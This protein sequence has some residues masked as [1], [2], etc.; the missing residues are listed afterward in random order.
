[1]GDVD[2]IAEAMMQMVKLGSAPTVELDIFSG[3]PLDYEYFRATFKDVVEAN[4]ETQR[5]KLTRLLRYISG[6]AKD[7]VKD[8]IHEHEDVCFD[9]A[10]QALE[11]EYGD[12][13][14][15][16]SAYMKELRQWPWIKPHDTK[17][18]RSMSRFLQKCQIGRRQGRLIVLDAPETIRLILSKYYQS[19]QDSWNKHANRLKQ[20]HQ[21]EAN[22]DT[23]LNFL[24]QQC[25]LLSNPYYSREAFQERERKPPTAHFKSFAT[26]TGEEHDPG[27]LNRGYTPRC[28]FCQGEHWLEKCTQMEHLNVVERM[29]FVKDKRLCF[30]CFRPANKARYANIFRSRLTCGLCGEQHPTLLHGYHEQT[31]AVLTVKRLTPGHVIS[32]SVV[33]VILYHKKRPDEAVKVYAMLNACSQGTFVDE[34]VIKNL[35]CVNMRSSSINIRTMNGM[36]QNMKINAVHG[37]SVVCTKVFNKHYPNVLMSNCQ[38]PTRKQVCRSV[39]KNCRR[40][41]I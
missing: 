38:P 21:K 2:P 22:F 3:N 17:A 35:S 34:S 13:Q 11:R 30:C 33:S 24:D 12:S 5:S 25:I 26:G 8:F 1:M 10:I 29:N 39:Q 9:M 23:L 20:T 14:R 6:E 27:R 18:Y 40:L 4:V 16:D 36:Q 7:I 15:L 28:Y 31:M 41:P 32:L 19:V 37:L